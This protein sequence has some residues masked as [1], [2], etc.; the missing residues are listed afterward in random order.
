MSWL[1]LS[2]HWL[3]CV[4]F[5]ILYSYFLSFH[6]LV[7]WSRFIIGV[8]LSVC[9]LHILYSYLR[10]LKSCCTGLITSFQQLYCC[11]QT[12]KAYHLSAALMDFIVQLSKKP[13]CFVCLFVHVCLWVFCILNLHTTIL[14]YKIL[15]NFYSLCSLTNVQLYERKKWYLLLEK[16][17]LLLPEKWYLLSQRNDIFFQR[18]DI[19]FFQSLIFMLPFLKCH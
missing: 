17:F 11:A 5:H 19:Y 2:A 1:I 13:N 6:L 4:I 12:Y 10:K 16:W 14:L 8:L 7:N 18:N 9:T 3:I 15:N